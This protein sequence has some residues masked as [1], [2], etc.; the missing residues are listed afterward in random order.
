MLL[1]YFGQLSVP[2]SLRVQALVAQLSAPR[3][4]LNPVLQDRAEA[5]KDMKAP[6]QHRLRELNTVQLIAL[7]RSYALTNQGS[8]ELYAKAAMHTMKKLH[9]LQ[10]E[11]QAEVC[12]YLARAKQ[13]SGQLFRSVEYAFMRDISKFSPKAVA[14]LSYAFWASGSQDFYRAAAEVFKANQSSF[15]TETG[16]L[17]LT[18]LANRKWNESSFHPS[19]ETWAAAVDGAQSLLVQV[20]HVLLRLQASD[21][22]VQ[23][24]E[25]KLEPEDMDLRT[26]EHYLGC[27]VTFGRQVKVEVLDQVKTLLEETEVDCVSVSKLIYTVELIPE[28]NHIKAA[29]QVFVQTHQFSSSDFALIASALIHTKTHTP[30]ISSQLSSHKFSVPDLLRLLLAAGTHYASV[31]P[32][33]PQVQES[34]AGHLFNSSE[35]VLLVSLLARMQVPLEA[36]WNA[37]AKEA[38]LVQ[39]EDAEQYIQLFSI[40]QTIKEVDTTETLKTLAGK[41]EAK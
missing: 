36:L 29:I 3:W 39:L 20:Y 6:V 11:Q 30:A 31:D 21:L 18:G 22:A 10:A 32:L 15:S 19:L 2:T 28:A 9:S 23:S 24:I 26:A 16:L 41:Y 35:F 25:A 34:L 4:D 27:C 33:W 40:L 12:Y 7:L 1:R 38:A 8:P 13:G 14:R 37:V 5:L 17:L